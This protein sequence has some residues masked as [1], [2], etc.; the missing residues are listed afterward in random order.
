MAENTH[1]AELT[2][3]VA[4]RDIELAMELTRKLSESHARLLDALE[5][6]L[7]LDLEGTDAFAEKVIGHARQVA[8]EAKGEVPDWVA[9]LPTNDGKA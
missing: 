2:R 7:T 4:A 8:K 5:T 1:F 6:L 3:A 9:P